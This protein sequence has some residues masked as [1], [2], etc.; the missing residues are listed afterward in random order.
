MPD[1]IN[2]VDLVNGNYIVRA[3]GDD[4]PFSIGGL[5]QIAIFDDVI[6]LTPCLDSSGYLLCWNEGLSTVPYVNKDEVIAMMDDI[7]H[8]KYN[9]WADSRGFTIQTNF[10]GSVVNVYSIYAIIND[11]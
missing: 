2:P 5:L 9:P 3:A 1:I 7:I 11:Q 4:L 6:A 8:Q 10:Q